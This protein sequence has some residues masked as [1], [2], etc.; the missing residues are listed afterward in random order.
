MNY[1]KRITLLLEKYRERTPDE[2]PHIR[3]QTYLDDFDAAVA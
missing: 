1:K 3:M 2:N